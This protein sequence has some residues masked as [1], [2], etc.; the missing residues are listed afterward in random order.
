MHE[1]GDE[2]SLGGSNI[3]QV[4]IDLDEAEAAGQYK[5]IATT[6]LYRV[7]NWRLAYKS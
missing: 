3:D 1:G 5:Q 2:L 7:K 4:F 6:K